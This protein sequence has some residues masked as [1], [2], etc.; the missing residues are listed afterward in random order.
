MLLS[1]GRLQSE[2]DRGLGF[3]RFSISAA[4]ADCQ[5]PADNRI[6]TGR[7]DQIPAVQAGLGRLAI[8]DPKSS[9]R[10]SGS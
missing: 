3:Q 10:L 5:R 6:P 1:A 4:G 8:A 9:F 7:S 2:A